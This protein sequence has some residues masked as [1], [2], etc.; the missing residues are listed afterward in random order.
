M[1]EETTNLILSLQ[2]D[3]LA[4]LLSKRKGRAAEGSAP[5]TDEELAIE[6]QRTELEDQQVLLADIRM[7]WSVSRAVQDDG[8]TVAILAAEERSS[9]QD[10]DMACRLS[11][12]TP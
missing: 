4:A 9:S 12:Q 8:A 1:D 5:G 7:V 2:M 3:D 11:D 6:L 10:R